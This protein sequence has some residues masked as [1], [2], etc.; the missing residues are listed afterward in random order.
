MLFYK[1]NA[2]LT[3]KNTEIDRKETR[4]IASIISSKSQMY[5]YDKGIDFHI[6]VS[7]ICYK[8]G[9]VTLCIASKFGDFNENLLTEYLSEI[10]LEITGYTV[11]EITL[12]AYHKALI[13]SERGEYTEHNNSITENLGIDNLTNR[14]ETTIKFE[15]VVENKHTKIQTIKG[16][17]NILCSDSFKEEIERIYMGSQNFEVK[18]HPVHYIMTYDDKNS[19]EMMLEYLID[20][21]QSNNRMLSRRYAV[22]VVRGYDEFNDSNSTELYESSVGSTVVVKFT[23]EDESDSQDFHYTT[24]AITCIT[25]AMKKYRNKVLTI[26]CLENKLEKCRSLINENLGDITVINLSQGNA[27]NQ[28]AKDYL[29]LR[30]KNHNTTNDRKLLTKVKKDTAYSASDLNEIFDNWYD[31]I[32]KEKVYSQYKEFE[33]ASENTLAKKVKGWAVKELDSMIGL[34]KAKH[35]IHSALDFY[36]A[37]KV[38]KIK[39]FIADRPS[40]HMVFTG[41]PGTAKTTVA[42][43]FAQIMKDNGSLSVGGLYEVGRADLVGKYVG[44]TAKIVKEK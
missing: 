25:N 5:F 44:W 43:L 13:M 12:K 42:R 39:G 10:D 11:N 24:H 31:R 27:F 14:H 37:Q 8:T 3:A 15:K 33:T 16:L 20:S 38:F 1:V 30:A 23:I 40:M 6:A 28:K 21:L 7:N 34:S 41:N 18:G 19:E 35:I 29:K 2:Q 17:E 4:E 9:V 26:F 22:T 36:K 32:L